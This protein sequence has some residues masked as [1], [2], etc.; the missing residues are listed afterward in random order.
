MN[1]KSAKETFLEM[2]GSELKKCAKCG[3]CLSVCPVYL[4]EPRERFSPRGKIAL[5][6]AFAEDDSLPTDALRNIVENCLLCR[7]CSEGCGSGVEFEKIIRSAKQRLLKAGVPGTQDTA[8]DEDG[9]FAGIPESSGLRG[10]YVPPEGG[11]DPV[12]SSP[13]FDWRMEEIRH[14][15]A[16]WSS[17]HRDTDPAGSTENRWR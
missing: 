8:S 6:E 15:C 3:A 2:A 1:D 12:P 17:F 13:A 10:R 5:C 9:V 11:E 14:T 16:P 4:Q 7:A